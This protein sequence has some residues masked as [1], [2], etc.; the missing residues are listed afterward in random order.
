MFSNSPQDNNKYFNHTIIFVHEEGTITFQLCPRGFTAFL[1]ILYLTL[2]VYTFNTST[3][4]QQ[5]NSHKSLT[6]Y[7]YITSTR[8]L[9]LQTTVG[10]SVRSLQVKPKNH[11]NIS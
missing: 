4:A 3:L 5:F 9:A 8:V 2:N 1:A 10:A 7:F 11:H 6:V